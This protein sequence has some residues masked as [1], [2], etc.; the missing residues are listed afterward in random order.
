[1]GEGD[2]D[3]VV[4]GQRSEA[5]VSPISNNSD[6]KPDLIIAP[7]QILIRGMDEEEEEDDE[8]EEEE[9]DDEQEM[10]KRK[11]KRGGKSKADKTMILTKTFGQAI[12]LI[13]EQKV[14]DNLPGNN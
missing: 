8:E 10:K 1:M 14:W 4:V 5:V 6:E 12:R 11:K 7:I 9:E 13:N 2:N 3:D